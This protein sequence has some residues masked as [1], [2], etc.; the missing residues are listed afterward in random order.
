M[1]AKFKAWRILLIAFITVVAAVPACIALAQTIGA[2]VDSEPI[3]E[4]EIDQR[5]RLNQLVTRKPPAREQVIDE[6]RREKAKV[7]DARQFGVE[8]SESEVEQAYAQIAA[9]MRFTSEQITQQLA[10]SGIDVETLKHRIR[11]DLAWQRHQ[12]WRRQD[13]PPRDRGGG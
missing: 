10:R 11:A 8:I 13:P 6:L 1:S 2:V 5:S 3:T 7:R 4:L 9:R 12:Q